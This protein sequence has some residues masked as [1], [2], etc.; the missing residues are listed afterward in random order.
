MNALFGH[1]HHVGRIHAHPY[2]IIEA[3][4]LALPVR[5][6]PLAGLDCQ[7][8][9]DARGADSTNRPVFSIGHL[10]DACGT[11][12]QGLGSIEAR[13]LPWAIGTAGA[14]VGGHACQ[15]AQ[16]AGLGRLGGL[17]G[18]RWLHPLASST[19]KARLVT[20]RDAAI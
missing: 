3:G 10:Q 11:Q 14:I 13:L 18:G 17:L 1:V 4:L 12:R 8:A 5:V 20:V 7:R 6:T 15:G 19:G 2:G 9:H 16:L